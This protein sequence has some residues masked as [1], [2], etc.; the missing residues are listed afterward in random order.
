MIPISTDGRS[1]NLIPPGM[2]AGCLK[3]ARSPLSSLDIEVINAT[4]PILFYIE[5]S[6]SIVSR[7]YCCL[8]SEKYLQEIW[9]NVKRSLSVHGISGELNLVSNRFFFLFLPPKLKNYLFY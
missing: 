6:S 2:R 5:P 9:P 1:R 3:S 8:N 4:E 7:F